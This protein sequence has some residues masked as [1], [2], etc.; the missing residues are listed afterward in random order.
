MKDLTFRIHYV[1]SGWIKLIGDIQEL[2]K[3]KP[4]A[5]IPLQRV[6]ESH[7]LWETAGLTVPDT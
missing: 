1:T 5:V 2:G 7:G 6:P 3:W 4:E